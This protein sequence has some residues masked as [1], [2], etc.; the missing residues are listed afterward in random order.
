MAPPTVT[1]EVVLGDGH[2]SGRQHRTSLRLSWYVADPLAVHVLLTA[3][4]DHP[5]LPRGQW[6]ML[7]DFLRYGLSH[8]T[9]DGDVR[10]RPGPGGVT[11]VVDLTRDGR[12]TTVRIA[13]SMV[14]DFLDATEDIVPAGEEQSAAALDELIERLTRA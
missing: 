7:R 4:P 10:V 14:R 9:G 1:A 3:Q 5:A 8:P 12:C 11:V 6:T 13:A 2:A